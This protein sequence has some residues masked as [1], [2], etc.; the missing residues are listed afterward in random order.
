MITAGLLLA[1][2]G[3]VDVFRPLVRRSRQWIVLIAI[4]LVVV[5]TGVLA[6]APVSGVVGLAGGA[7]WVWLVPM[8]RRG[9][10][11][12]WPVIGLALACAVALAVQGGREET[13]LWDAVGPL[14]SPVGDISADQVV[15]VVGVVLFLLESANSV[16]RV[17]LAVE[18]VSLQSTRDEAARQSS[19]ALKGGRLIGPIE[20]V[21]VFSLTLAVAYPLLAA[22]IAAKG[23][24]RFPEISRDSDQGNRAEY[25]LVGSLVSWVQALAAAFTVWWC[26]AG[27]R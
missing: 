12:F 14:P 8:G 15:L 1:T 19:S 27:S 26:F 4:A 20:R 3:L 9:R 18:G 21:I 17:A 13:G 7:A 5:A 22:F 10:A 24:V 11:G 25:F 2:I 16:V 6:G 23:I